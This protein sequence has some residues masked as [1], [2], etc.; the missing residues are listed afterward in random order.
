MLI[1]YAIGLNGRD[2]SIENFDFVYNFCKL[3]DIRLIA[4]EVF[5]SFLFKLTYFGVF[6]GGF[7]LIFST[8]LKK[9]KMRLR[10]IFHRFLISNLNNI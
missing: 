10:W 9:Q 8:I 5:C 4:L 7:T 6:G 1:C 3:I 2:Q